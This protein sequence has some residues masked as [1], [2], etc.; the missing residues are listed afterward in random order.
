MDTS[1]IILLI[2]LALI[3]L[4]LGVYLGYLLSRVKSQKKKQR[5][6][7]EKLL[8]LSRQRKEH[9]VESII[10]IARAAVQDQCELSEACIRIK[11]LLENYPQVAERADFEIIA[12]MYGELSGF[13]YLEERKALSKQEKFNQ[14]KKRFLV[15]DKFRDPM[16]KSLKTLITTFEEMRD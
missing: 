16:L 6:S 4:S 1:N 12:R 7:E 14:D 2:L 5:D 13:A 15:E 3:T 11:K 10:T 9:L 8:E